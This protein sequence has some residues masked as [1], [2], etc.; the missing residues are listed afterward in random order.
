MIPQ[1]SIIEYKMGNVYS[2]QQACINAGMNA[3]ITDKRQVIR[4]SHAIILPGVGA[5]KS[6]MDEL[7]RLDLIDVIKD[8]AQSGKIIIGICLGMQLLVSESSE[9]GMTRGLDLIEGKTLRLKENRKHVLKV[10]QIGWNRILPGPTKYQ[11]W[12]GTVLDGVDFESYMYFVHSFF[13]EPTESDVVLTRTEYG[14]TTYCSA[15][16][17]D[18]IIGFQ[19]HPERSGNGGMKIYKNISEMLQNNTD[20]S[21]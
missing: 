15:F 20:N 4:D 12:K 13:V 11:T 1:I 14:Q 7:T 19:F 2:I 6:A 8:E 21:F 17:K 3:V 5:F 10:P 16:V 18:N 9:F